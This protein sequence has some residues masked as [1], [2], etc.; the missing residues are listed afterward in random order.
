ML[1]LGAWNSLQV[2]V[3]AAKDRA[4]LRLMELSETEMYNAVLRGWDEWKEN[5]TAKIMN[6]FT[7][8]YQNAEKILQCDGGNMYST[9]HTRDNEEIK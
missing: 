8:M 1:D 9:P 3:D 5:A 4:G 7:Q 6:L 2:A